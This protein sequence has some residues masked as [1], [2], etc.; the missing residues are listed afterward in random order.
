MKELDA[1]IEKIA[2]ILISC[3]NAAFKLLARS[4]RLSIVREEF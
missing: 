2:V 3:Q 1:L 4:W